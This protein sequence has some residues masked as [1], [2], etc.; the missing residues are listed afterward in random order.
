M[1]DKNEVLFHVD[2]TEYDDDGTN[3]INQALKDHGSTP[4]DVVNVESIAGMFRV[5][6][7]CE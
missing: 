4:D 5:W 6:F 2:I 1:C 7:K 3:E